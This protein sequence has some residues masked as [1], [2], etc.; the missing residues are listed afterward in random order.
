MSKS[1]TQTL[2]KN[3]KIK[4]YMNDEND[5]AVNDGR[6]IIIT[7]VIEIDDTTKNET[8]KEISLNSNYLCQAAIDHIDVTK[9]NFGG[10]ADFS[11]TGFKLKLSEK[12]LPTFANTSNTALL[13]NY[14]NGNNYYT[15]L[16]IGSLDAGIKQ[17]IK[18][19]GGL[20]LSLN[21]K[22]GSANKCGIIMFYC[23]DKLAGDSAHTCTTIKVKSGDNYINFGKFNNTTRATSYTLTPGIHVLEIPKSA[24]SIEIYADTDTRDSEKTSVTDYEYSYQSNIIFS[25]LSVIYD[26]NP[27]LNYHPRAT[28]TSAYEQLLNDI[29]NTKVADNFYYNCPVDNSNAIEIN[30]FIEDETLASPYV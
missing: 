17:S 3:E 10:V 12:L 15:K 2:H 14:S 22:I 13:D 20:C 6:P 28:N 8:V 18:D 19:A 4:I 27:K 11:T 9:V 24:S 21:T 30:E 5:R 29:R 7:P 16:S 1:T 25:K 23:V 26:I